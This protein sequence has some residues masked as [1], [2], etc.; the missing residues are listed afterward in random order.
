MSEESTTPDLVELTRRSIEALADSVEAGVSFYAPDGVWDASWGMGVHEGQE[1]VGGFFRDWR[2]AYDEMTREIETIR[3]FGNGV[4][5]AVIVQTG[6]VGGSSG[7]VQLRYGSVMEWSS[8]RIV[9]NTTY[10]DTDEA[11]AAAE[12]LAQERG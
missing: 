1:A 4:T 3:D 5:F 8:G 2:S 9:R 11:R 12:R 6:R 10:T 7:S